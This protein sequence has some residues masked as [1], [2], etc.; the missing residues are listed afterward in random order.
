MSPGLDGHPK[1][2]RS[3]R[4]GREVFLFI[5]RRNADL[6]LNGR[7]PA[8]YAEHWYLA[9][10]LMMS[11]AE[12]E[13][14]VSR[15][16]TAG[17]LTR[18]GNHLSIVGWD[19]EW[20]KAP[21]DEAERK[22]RQREREKASAQNNTNP[23]KESRNVT[24]D[25]V[26]HSDGPDSHALEESRSE[27]KRVDEKRERE[28]AS[29]PARSSPGLADLEKAVERNLGQVGA[30][31]GRKP[32]PSDPTASELASVRVILDKLGAQNGV[33]YRD[34]AEHTKLIVN[35][36]RLGVTEMELRSIVGYCAIEKDWKNKPEMQEYLRPETLFGPKTIAKYLDPARTWFEKLEPDKP[37][38]EP[39][40]EPDWMQGGVA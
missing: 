25:N 21:L 14:G 34:S 1:I 11:E 19:D 10:Q 26:T 33:R 18:E 35:Q 31:R 12:A 24:I 2:R 29:P 13:E 6:D 22:R 7:V 39:Y 38:S 40:D 30:A 36:L 8:R 4:N 17:L 5:L 20:A 23:E 3:G 28:S 15:C 37:P 32:K 27:E 9:D 16:V